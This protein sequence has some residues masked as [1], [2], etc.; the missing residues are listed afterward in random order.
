MKRR[1]GVSHAWLSTI[2]AILF[3]SFFS[4][5]DSDDD[6]DDIILE[7]DSYVGE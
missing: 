6:L 3:L 2:L 1:M 7:E 5:K 4:C